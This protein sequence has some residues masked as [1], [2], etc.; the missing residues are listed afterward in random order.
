MRADTLAYENAHNPDQVNTYGFA[1]PTPC[2]SETLGPDAQYKGAIDSHAYS[3]A[4][5]GNK[6]VVADAGGN[7]LLLVD[8]EGHISTLA[9]LP[10][11]PV[12]RSPRRAPSS[13]A[14]TPSASWARPTASSRFRPTS[15]SAT[16]G[17]ST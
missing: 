13:W 17:C 3:V 10:P 6:W 12:T 16:T 2:Q 11:Q 4:S 5:W 7:D 8:N 15:R 14:S 9:V 1:H